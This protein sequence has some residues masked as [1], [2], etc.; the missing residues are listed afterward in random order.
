[1]QL[2]SDGVRSVQLVVL[3]VSLY[4]LRSF[5]CF[6]TV[7]GITF[8]LTVTTSCCGHSFLHAFLSEMLKASI[9]F[10]FYLTG[11]MSCMPYPLTWASVMYNELLPCP[12]TWVCLFPVLSSGLFRS[13]P[14]TPAI[15]LC[16]FL[17]LVQ[18]FCAVF[19]FTF[20]KVV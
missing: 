9:N 10:Q 12:L 6:L 7:C 2:L 16:L 3:V 14:A 17:V 5:T 13:N 19:L 20:D 1:M 11:F 18:P 15:L 8:S 4:F